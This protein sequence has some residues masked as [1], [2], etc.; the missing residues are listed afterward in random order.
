[1]KRRIPI[2]VVA[3]FVACAVSSVPLQARH[4]PS[5][6]ELLNRIQ[7]QRNPVKKAK[8]EVRLANLKL[9]EAI[10]AYDGQQL[11]Q[12]AGLLKVYLSEV[13]EAWHTLQATGRDPTKKPQGYRD[14]EISLREDMRD[15]SEARR[16][17]YYA[18]RGPID[19]TQSQVGSLHAK[20]LSA[21]FPGINGNP[22]I[23][24]PGNSLA[25][26]PGK[27]RQ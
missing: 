12:G 4:A 10:S 11:G 13:E 21:L 2:T 6:P 20:V 5:E 17:T 8:L 23:S 14:L 27:V 24:D 26:A 19:Q 18:N 9:K 25:S 1:M 7:N 15:L 22:A 3:T 16:R